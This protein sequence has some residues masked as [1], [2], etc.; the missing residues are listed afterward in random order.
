LAAAIVPIATAYSIAEGVG[1]PA[2]LD[3][4]SHHFQWFYAAFIGL[5]IAAVS[6]VSL[7][8]LPLIPL[9]YTS[10]VVNAVLLPLHV[11]ALQLLAADAAIMGKSRSG[12]WPRLLGWCSITLVVACVVAL[13]WS[14]LGGA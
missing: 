1:E 13:G 11:I 3:L 2:S 7:P 4:D 6:V 9:I 12:P 8:G 14:W 5:T 10:Q